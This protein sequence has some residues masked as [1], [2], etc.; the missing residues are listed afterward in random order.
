[1]ASNSVDSA[2]NKVKVKA[3]FKSIWLIIAIFNGFIALLMRH[4]DLKRHRCNIGAVLFGNCRCWC[5][6]NY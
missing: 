4:P 1:M 6:V 3:Q 5:F 2:I